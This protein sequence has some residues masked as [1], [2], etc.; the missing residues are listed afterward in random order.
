MELKVANKS[1]EDINNE[2]F[3]EIIRSCDVKL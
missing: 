1:D 2:I 3:T